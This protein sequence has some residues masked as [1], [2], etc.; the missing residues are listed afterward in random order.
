MKNR[1]RIALWIVAALAVVFV[2]VVL[3]TLMAQD[4]APLTADTIRKKVDE[5]NQAAAVTVPEEFESGKLCRDHMDLCKSVDADRPLSEKESSDYRITFQEVICLKQPTLRRF[6]RNLTVLSN[7]DMSRPNNVGGLGIAGSHDHHDESMRS[8]LRDIEG[9]ISTV[10]DHSRSVY[11]RVKAAVFVYKDL[12]DV[13]THLATIPHTKSTAYEPP[14][15]NDLGDYQR[16]GEAM[17]IDFKAAQFA[18]ING[19]EYWAAL[20]RGLDK[21]DLPA[22]SVQQA[23]NDNLSPLERRLTGRWGSVQSLGPWLT[24]GSKPRR[25]RPMLAKSEHR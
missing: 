19:P 14:S 15:K 5:I 25:Y 10:K 18:P 9:E 2:G 4:I 7:V 16:A 21:F 6:D 22:L 3:T 20:S 8:N 11:S 12:S 23:V 13:L 1:A 17:L 24:N